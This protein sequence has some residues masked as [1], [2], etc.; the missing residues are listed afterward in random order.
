MATTKLGQMK[1]ADAPPTETEEIEAESRPRE[2]ETVAQ[3]LNRALLSLHARRGAAYGRLRRAL[4]DSI[5]APAAT[6]RQ[7]QSEV[8]NVTEDLKLVSEGVAALRKGIYYDNLPNSK[9]ALKWLDR[10]QKLEDRKLIAFTS[11]SAIQ[12]SRAAGTAPTT[13]AETA[14]LDAKIAQYTREL[15]EVNTEESDIFDEVREFIAEEL[16]ED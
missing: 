11:L 1:V 3:S 7:L 6:L 4:K 8:C 15:D 9:Q 12:R 13:P 10:I 16:D 14:E 2:G 5:S